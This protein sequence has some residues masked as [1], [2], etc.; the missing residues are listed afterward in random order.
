MISL[1]SNLEIA[2]RAM[3]AN[4]LAMSVIGSNIA[5]VNTPGYSRRRAAIQEAGGIDVGVGRV[6]AGAQVVDIRRVRDSILDGLYRKHQGDVGRWTGVEDYLNKVET[7]MN[8]PGSGGLGDVMGAFWASWE[9]LANEPE[10]ETA[11]SQVRLRGQALCESFHR[12]ESH[13]RGLQAS[14]GDEVESLVGQVNQ[15]SGQLAQINRMIQESE[16]GGKEAGG[17]R[18]ERDVLIDTLSEIVNVQVEETSVY[19]RGVCR[20]C[21]TPSN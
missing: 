8:E 10:N 20:D 16:L 1:N 2:R 18:D 14:L 5:N 12:L 19:F 17:L 6:G 21:A 9:D 4:Q 7:L 11:R 3:Q 13:L 15:L